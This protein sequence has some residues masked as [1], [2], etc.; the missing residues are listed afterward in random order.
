MIYSC[1][2]LN[3]GV[4]GALKRIHGPKREEITGDPRKLHNEELHNL[5][6]LPNIITVNKRRTMG[7]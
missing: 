6:S 7:M 3:I 5:H 1:I 4:L 2:W